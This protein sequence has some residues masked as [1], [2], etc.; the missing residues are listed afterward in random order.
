MSPV[1]AFNVVR[2]QLK[3]DYQTDGQ[4]DPNVL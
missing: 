1:A 4:T 3:S 2:L